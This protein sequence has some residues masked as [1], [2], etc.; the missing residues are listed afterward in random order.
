[1]TSELLH[2]GQTFPLFELLSHVQFNPPSPAGRCHSMPSEA[3]MAD[4]LY[5]GGL[6]PKVMAAADDKVS[7]WSESHGVQT[8]PGSTSRPLAL[9][10]HSAPWVI[11][12]LSILVAGPAPRDCRPYLSWCFSHGCFHTSHR[13]NKGWLFICSHTQRLTQQVIANSLLL[14]NYLTLTRI[15]KSNCCTCKCCVHPTKT[16]LHYSITPLPHTHTGRYHS[17]QTLLMAS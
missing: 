5:G 14:T 17:L 1:M 9:Y 8:P 13:K 2:R 3:L 6:L 7:W 4:L 16:T 11:S 12:S 15:I 10:R